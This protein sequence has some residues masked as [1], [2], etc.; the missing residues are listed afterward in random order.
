MLSEMPFRHLLDKI[1]KRT[2]FGFVFFGFG[3]SVQQLCSKTCDIYSAAQFPQAFCFILT[4]LSSVVDGRDGISD[5]GAD[6]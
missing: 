1:V 4:L 2:V 3:G 5:H 6:R